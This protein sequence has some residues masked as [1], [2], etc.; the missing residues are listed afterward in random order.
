MNF[1]IL[2][3]RM[4]EVD[5]GNKIPAHKLVESTATEESLIQ[6]GN[7]HHIWLWSAKG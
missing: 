4:V 7:L 5:E 6:T 2:R 3:E 1:V